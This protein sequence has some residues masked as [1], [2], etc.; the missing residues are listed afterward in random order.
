MAQRQEKRLSWDTNYS[1]LR[2]NPRRKLWKEK[3][4]SCQTR[5]GALKVSKSIVFTLTRPFTLE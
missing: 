2:V 1:S 5:E 4:L 3:N